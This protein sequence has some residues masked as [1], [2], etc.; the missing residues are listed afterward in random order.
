[1]NQKI[2]FALL[3]FVLPLLAIAQ[4]VRGTVTDATTNLPVLGATVVV[5][6][7]S[8]G[9]STD[10]DGKFTLNDVPLDAVIVVN[11]L[12][13]TPMELLYTGQET[14]NVNLSQDASQLDAIVLIGY[15]EVK[16]ENVTAAQFF[17]RSLSG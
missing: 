13:Y 11:Y 6:G 8:N 10:F 2:K 5:K 15:G 14:L 3:L 17:Q 1:M 9:T 12:G 7:T 4:T 16:R